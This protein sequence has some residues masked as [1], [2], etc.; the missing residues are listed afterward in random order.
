VLVLARARHPETGRSVLHGRRTT[1]LLASQELTAWGMTALWLGAYYRTYPTSV[2]A[3]V[4]A[5]LA[6]PRDFVPGPFT[7]R[8]EGP[9]R[10]RVGFVVRDGNYLS[11]RY[12]VDAYAFARAFVAMLAEREPRG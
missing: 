8:R 9:S 5:A 4:T 10:P 11:A 2:Q 1:A 6:H 3:E 12:Y 7:I